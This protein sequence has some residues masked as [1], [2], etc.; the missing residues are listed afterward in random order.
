M[1]MWCRH[2]LSVNW[3]AYCDRLPLAK[4]NPGLLFSMSQDSNPTRNK[5]QKKESEN[6]TSFSPKLV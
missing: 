3:N 2:S 6:Y 5:K 4:K 1:H